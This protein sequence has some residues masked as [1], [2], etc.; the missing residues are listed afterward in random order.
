[1]ATKCIIG[2]GNPRKE[3]ERTRHN[4]GF[5]AVEMLAKQWG[6]SWKTDA[7]RKSMIAEGNIE[8][9]KVVLVKPQTYMNN[10]GEAVRLMMEYLHIT[11]AEI[12]VIADDVALPLGT[13]RVRSDGSAGGHN[14]FKSIIEHIGT[15]TF[16]RIRI[17]VN[18][19]PTDVPLEV[20]VLEKFRKTEHAFIDKIMMKIG[21]L[22]A[23]PGGKLLE[24]THT[25][26]T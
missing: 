15:Q 5:M 16:V 17:G 3:Y 22:L 13:I 18:P 20:Y 19:P 12:V 6:F 1:M 26:D 24:T 10:S 9:T 8:G 7:G 23:V 21:E 14:G 4:A 25:V 2:L 11:P